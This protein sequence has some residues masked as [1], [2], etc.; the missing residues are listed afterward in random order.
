MPRTDFEYLVGSFQREGFPA[1][2]A[3]FDRLPL[4]PYIK[5]RFR[6]RRYSHFRGPSERMQRLDHTSFLQSKQVNYLAGGIR[7]EFEE[8]EDGLL[9]EVA[10]RHVVQSFLD[11]IGI[12]PLVREYGVHQIRICCSQ[13]FSGDPAPEGIHQDGFDYV[14][15]FC[16]DR[17]QIVGA[18]TLLYRDPKGEP[19]FA[20]ALQPGEAVF[21]NDRVLYHY[22]DPVRPVGAGQGHRDVFVLTA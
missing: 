17:H 16:I 4:D 7:R 2:G 21:T 12:D 5:G 6:R 20:R 11:T 19:V 8:L 18:N 3:F 15:I 9:A 22:T 13:E 1:L 10:F 14:G